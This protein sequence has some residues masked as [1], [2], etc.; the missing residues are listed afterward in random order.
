MEPPPPLSGL[1]TRHHLGGLD[2]ACGPASQ[3]P[4]QPRRIRQ[5]QSLALEGN[6]AR[7]RPAAGGLVAFVMTPAGCVEFI[8]RRCPLPAI[9][10]AAV[11]P[12]VQ[13]SGGEGF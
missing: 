3:L 8:G 12:M 2:H 13:V 10:V 6:V 7:T 1:L 9:A 11:V 4:G 5:S